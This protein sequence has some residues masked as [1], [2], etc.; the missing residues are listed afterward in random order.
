ML[1][2]KS[3]S[4]FDSGFTLIELMITVAIL[5]LV[6]A[7]AIPSFNSLTQGNRLTNSANQMLSAFKT[8]RSEAIKRSQ[9]TQLCPTVDGATCTESANWQNWLITI[10][11]EIVAQG[12]TVS[13]IE[14]TG[15]SNTGIF[16]TSNGLVRDKNGVGIA[17]AMRVCS[18]S[19][20]VSENT[21]TLSFVAG[22]GISIT[23]GVTSCG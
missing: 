8:A 19:S 1:R 22:G 10:G 18:T 16:F 21:R 3:V 15:P 2:L 20:S 13:G 11:N 14:V 6:A 4:R 23:R 12:R 7:V 17:S 9:T 5:A